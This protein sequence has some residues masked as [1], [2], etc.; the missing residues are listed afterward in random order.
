MEQRIKSVMAA[1]LNIDPRSIGDDATP[2]T[3]LN[4]DSLRHMTLVLALEDEFGVQFS[5]QQIPE[6]L[7]YKKIVESLKVLMQQNRGNTTNAT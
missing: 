1:A 7:S 3:L 6:L 2:D 4:W 5:D